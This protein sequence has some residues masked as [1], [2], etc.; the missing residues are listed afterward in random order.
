MRTCLT[1]KVSFEDRRL[2]CPNDGD[3]LIDEGKPA[4]ETGLA[5]GPYRLGNLLGEGGM[6]RVFEARGETGEVVA[7][8]VL[9]EALAGAEQS[10]RRFQVEAEA[11]AALEH[12]GV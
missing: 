11:A 12:P 8:K 4:P 5:L 3:V 6:G 10:Q 7:V 9:Q 1:C 2:I